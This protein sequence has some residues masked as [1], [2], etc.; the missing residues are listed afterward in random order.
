M[1]SVFDSFSSVTTIKIQGGKA[2][3]ADIEITNVNGARVYN[4]DNHSIGEEI[5]LGENLPA[6]VYFV[7]I[8]TNTETKT[9]KV[10]K[11]Q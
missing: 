6:G 2:D 10:V 1:I 9:M 7:R 3:K 5:L 8:N 4:K 11:L